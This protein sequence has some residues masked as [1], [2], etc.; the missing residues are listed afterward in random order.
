MSTIVTRT[1]KGT[2]LTNVEL[3][4]NFTNLNADKL[5]KSNNL[6]DLNDVALARA[7]IGLGSSATTD[8]TAYA[9]ALQGTKA[10]S[11]VQPSALSLVATTGSYSDLVGYPIVSNRV[12]QNIS[13]PDGFNMVLIDPTEISP[14]V[15]ITGLGNSTLRG[16]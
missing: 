1:G 16:I 9:T 5:E 14:D 13:I 12:A 4:A 2:P 10:D 8:S 11:A 6:N 7:N 15:T 3:D